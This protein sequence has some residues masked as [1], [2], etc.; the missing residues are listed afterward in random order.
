MLHAAD[1]GRTAPRTTPTHK[2]NRSAQENA[3]AAPAPARRASQ[4]E[5][6]ELPG[7]S[8]T[9]NSEE[10]KTEEA[11]DKESVRNR[12]RR[13]I[14]IDAI[15]D[16]D[17]EYSDGYETEKELEVASP[18]LIRKRRRR[19]DKQKEDLVE[20]NG[21]KLSKMPRRRSNSIH[22]VA[23]DLLRT[24]AGPASSFGASRK[25]DSPSA[26]NAS[27]DEEGVS[28][29]LRAAKMVENRANTPRSHLSRVYSSRSSGHTEGNSDSTDWTRR[30][31]SSPSDL[32]SVTRGPRAIPAIRIGTSDE[33]PGTVWQAVNPVP[34]SGANQPDAYQMT[35]TVSRRSDSQRTS[36]LYMAP[37]PRELRRAASEQ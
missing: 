22:A 23:D 35:E 24:A 28:A 27:A 17:N 14:V 25:S 26:D 3:V 29:L 19:L 6:T 18:L 5:Q 7:S 1:R 37:R 21:T 12:K 2:Q 15:L 36:E 31:L 32:H 34:K 20:N 13:G 10:A 16:D 30:P 33:H 9:K 11:K 8:L 4:E